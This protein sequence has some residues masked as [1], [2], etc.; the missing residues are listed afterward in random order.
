VIS[1]TLHV[2]E[3]LWSP[4]RVRRPKV[5][6][7]EAEN[8]NESNLVLDDLILALLGRD[9]AEI[10]VAPGVAADLVTL[11][12]HAL[13]DGR[14]AGGGVLYLALSS[15]GSNNE[16]GRLD[17][18]LLQEVQKVRCV[19]VRP[20]IKCQG[21][22]PGDGAVADTGSVGYGAE[23]RAR[24]RGRILAGRCLVAVTGRPKAQL[25]TWCSAEG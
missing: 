16:E 18:I 1:Q 20:I 22:L 25:T 11:G 3:C 13:D 19:D 10:L 21:N 12:E 2:I 23:E 9:D 6:W 8:V 14:I 15:V 4:S 7:E 24:D 17:V 5:R